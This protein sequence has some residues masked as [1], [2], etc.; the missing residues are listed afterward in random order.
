M[1][2]RLTPDIKYLVI[3][4]DGPGSKGDEAMLTGVCLF[5]EET[6]WHCHAA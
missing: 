4:P 3:A 5:W 6:M 1:A 2:M